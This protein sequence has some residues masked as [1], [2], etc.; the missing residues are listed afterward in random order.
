MNDLN[1]STCGKTGCNMNGLD[2]DIPEM[3]KVNPNE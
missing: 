3:T 2:K 1:F